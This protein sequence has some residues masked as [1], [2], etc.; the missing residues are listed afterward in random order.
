MS[1]AKKASILGITAG[2]LSGTS[3]VVFA[4]GA[5]SLNGAGATFPAP[6]YQS[7]FAGLASSGIKVN[8]QSVGSGAGVRQFVA[9]TVDFGAS[10]EPIKA[11]EANKVKRGVVQFPSVGGTI[12]IGYNKP[13]CADLKLTQKQLVEIFLGQINNWSQIGR[14]HV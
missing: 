7:A 14:A 9:G 13:G 6:F 8:Y 3:A 5:P 1:F 2:L 11:S 12:A 10:D 4:Q